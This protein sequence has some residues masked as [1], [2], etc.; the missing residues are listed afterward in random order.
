MKVYIL[1]AKENWITDIL[2]QEWKENN[3]YTQ[4]TYMKQTL[5]GYCLIILRIIFQDSYI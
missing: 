5:Y 4:I 3:F 2:A 1:Y